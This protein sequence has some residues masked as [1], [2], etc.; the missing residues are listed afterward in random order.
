MAKDVPHNYLEINNIALSK[1]NTAFHSIGLSGLIEKS[2]SN[3]A[4]FKLLIKSLF[5]VQKMWAQPILRICRD[6]IFPGDFRTIM[7]EN[8]YLLQ[9]QNVIRSLDRGAKFHFA[10]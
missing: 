5:S 4:D 2:L 3:A 7:F 1:T 10:P 8:C 6:I 9:I